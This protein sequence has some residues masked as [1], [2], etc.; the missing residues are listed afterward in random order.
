MILFDFSYFCC[1]VLLMLL[2]FQSIQNYKHIF[3]FNILFVYFYIS[4]ISDCFAWDNYIPHTSIGSL[5][6]KV[7]PLFK[8]KHTSRFFIAI[9][10]FGNVEAGVV[11]HSKSLTT[12]FIHKSFVYSVVSDY[13]PNMEILGQTETAEIQIG[14]TFLIRDSSCPLIGWPSESAKLPEAAGPKFGKPR[15]GTTLSPFT[16]TIKYDRSVLCRKKDTN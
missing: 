11:T 12:D 13:S 9:S 15:S 5:V 4:L 8:S 10:W 3:T 7:T 6:C 16:D 14:N 1:M 2:L